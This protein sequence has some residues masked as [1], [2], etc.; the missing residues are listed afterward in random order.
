LAFASVETIGALAQLGEHLL[1]KQGV[2]GSIPL[3]STIFGPDAVALFERCAPDGPPNDRR[4][5]LAL[6]SFASLAVEALLSSEE[7]KVC[8]THLRLCLFCKIVKRRLIW[9][10]PGIFGF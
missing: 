4:R 1:C 5:P 2:N 3:S 7:N 9:M 10:L 6:R 8:T